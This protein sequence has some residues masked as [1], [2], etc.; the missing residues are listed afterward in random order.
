M[1]FDKKNYYKEYY[2]KNRQRYAKSI[3]KYQNSEKG[4]KKIKEYMEKNKEK[5]N[6][7]RRNYDKEKRNIEGYSL[8]KALEIRLR[9]VIIRY[10]QTG[11]IILPKIYSVVMDA[12]G[13]FGI[14]YEKIIEYLKPFPKDFLEKY[15]VDHIVPLHYFNFNNLEEIKWAFAPENHQIIKRG[16]NRSKGKKIIVY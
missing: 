12:H 7:W 8:R 3:K 13:L 6:E 14:E 11:E 2:K 10:I 4:K 9:R 15:E 1:V 5:L 16:K